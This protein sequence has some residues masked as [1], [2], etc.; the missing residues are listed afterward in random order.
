MERVRPPRPSDDS[1]PETIGALPSTHS[2]AVLLDVVRA[3][4]VMR[5][6]VDALLQGLARPL[7]ENESPRSRA[8]LLLSLI[9]SEEVGDMVGSE[10]T[11]VRAVAVQALLDMGYPYAL[12][13]PPEAFGGRRAALPQELP[14]PG[15]I[16]TLAGFIIQS[17][18]CVPPVLEL[19]GRESEPDKVLGLIVLSLLLGPTFMSVLG[20]ALRMRYLQR[21]GLITMTITG[22]IWLIILAL[23][24]ATTGHPLSHLSTYVSLVA[25]LGFLLGAF[26][27]R[28]PGWLAPDEAPPDE[29][30][31]TEP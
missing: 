29:A 14:V 10:G 5:S 22:A 13:I 28:T 18:T 31:E 4:G 6:D 8:D 19:L 21:L 7:S 23:Q 16:A 2:L 30:P 11:P 12:E 3:P 26:F 27:T 20:G 1:G 17:I 15:L 9:E 25:G 24:L